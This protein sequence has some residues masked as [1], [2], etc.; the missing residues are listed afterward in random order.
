[1]SFVRCVPVAF[2]LLACVPALAQEGRQQVPIDK[3]AQ[4]EGRDVTVCGPIDSARHTP[5]VQGA[6]TLLHMGGAFPHHKFSARVWEQDR[7]KFDQDL[8]SLVGRMACVSG[9]VAMVSKRP[10]VVLSAPRDLAVF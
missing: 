5:N 10:E 6:P 1:M 8:E 9:R 3:A 2:A 7:A 4:Y